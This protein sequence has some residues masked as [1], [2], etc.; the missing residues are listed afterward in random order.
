[1]AVIHQLSRVPGPLP[2][3]RPDS[4]LAPA[5]TLDQDFA[6]AAKAL[7]AAYRQHGYRAASIDPLDGRPADVSQI[8]ELNPRSY[9]LVADESLALSVE[10]GG[11][12]LSVTLSELTS[13]LQASYCGSIALECG[14]VRADDQ[15]RW[16]YAR[17][18]TM[19]SASRLA[20][21]DARRILE[22]LVATETF[23]HQRRVAYAQYKQ[24]N[25]EGSESFVPLVRTVIEEAVRRGAESAVLAMPHRG[26]LNVMLNA[27]DVPVDRLLSLLSPNPDAALVAHDLRDHAGLL[28]RIETE[29]G[30]IDIVLLHNPS[31]L[32]SVSPVVC[33]MARA[34]QDRT[35]SGSTR[36]VLPV[37]VHGDA[38]F[39]AQ[40]VVAETFNLSQTRGYGVGGTVHL[41]LN[42]QSARRCRIRA[43][44][45]RRCPAPISR[46]GSMRRSCT[47]TRTIPMQSL[48][49]RGWRPSS[50]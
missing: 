41:I 24:F 2:D 36:K 35:A 47:S 42:N 28:S 32:E 8:A 4:N 17:M 43:I 49:R 48:R 50:A 39:S 5:G 30:G 44:S 15:V 29:D 40:G 20:N 12:A 46:A 37:L 6:Y 27:L 10:L 7:V 21:A 31:H 1:M 3:L 34:L 16:L 23:E 22:Q 18:E 19:S 25:L 13:R 45:A 9:G 14:H 11:L 26:R 33:G 38:S